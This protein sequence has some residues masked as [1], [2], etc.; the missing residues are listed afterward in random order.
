MS[1]WNEHLCFCLMLHVKKGRKK[2]IKDICFVLILFIYA[3]NISFCCRG[4]G[5]GG[6]LAVPKGAMLISGT[7]INKDP[8]IFVFSTSTLS[9]TPTP[10]P[11]HWNRSCNTREAC[12][13]THSLHVAGASPQRAD[14]LSAQKPDICVVWKGKKSAGKV[15]S[16]LGS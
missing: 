5:V 3:A 7:S 10:P 14:G 1:Y 6:Q 15:G 13:P 16:N 11:C 12:H 9:S 2:W 4:R 8:G